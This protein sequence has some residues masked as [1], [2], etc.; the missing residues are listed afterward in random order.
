MLHQARMAKITS[1][2]LAD[3]GKNTVDFMPN[4]DESLRS[5]STSFQ[6]PE[7]SGKRF[8]GHCG[9]HGYQYSAP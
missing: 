5:G 6:V 4:F 1:E 2:M 7:P 8:F 3:I 9:G